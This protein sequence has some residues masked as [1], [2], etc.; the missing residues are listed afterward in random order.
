MVQDHPGNDLIVP[1]WFWRVSIIVLPLQWLG[2]MAWWI[3]QSILE[4][5]S[6]GWW[7]P[8]RE[9]SL[10]TCLLQWGIILLLLILTNRHLVRRL[11]DH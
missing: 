7:N 6:E 3:T 5:D 9:F 2:L 8:F 1:V 4:F 11:H 10:G